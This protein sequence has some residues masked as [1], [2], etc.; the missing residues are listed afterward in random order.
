MQRLQVATGLILLVALAGLAATKKYTPPR[1]ALEGLHIA[2]P[3]DSAELIF[4]KIA[5]RKLN[6]KIDSLSL[7]ESD[8]VTVFGQPA[9]VQLQMLRG[10]VRSIVVNFHPLGGGI[11]L[12]TRKALLTHMEKY[13]GRGVITTNES[14]TYRRWETEDGTHEVSYSDKYFRLFVRL[15]KR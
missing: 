5:K 10:K 4:R 15:G 1:P 13:F 6:L 8:S 14:V 3:T 11:Y 12:D 2:M 7:L 9:Y